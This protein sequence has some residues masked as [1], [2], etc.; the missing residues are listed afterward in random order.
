MVNQFLVTTA[1]EDTWPNSQDTPIIFLGEWCRLYSAKERWSR[2][3]ADVLPYHWDNRKKLYKDYQYLQGFYEQMLNNLSKE[4]NEIHSV[5]HST[6]YWRILV[7]PWL[8]FFIQMLFDRWSSIEQ[9]LSSYEV[10]E[11]II[12]DFPLESLVPQGMSDFHNYYISDEWNHYIYGQILKRKKNILLRNINGKPIKLFNNEKKLKNTRKKLSKKIIGE[13]LSIINRNDD[14]FFML[15]Y[16]PKIMQCKLELKLK[17]IPKF[18]FSIP[19]LRKSLNFNQRA[20]EIGMQCN[21]EFESIAKQLIPKMIPALYLEGYHSLVG[22]SKNVPWPK[23]PKVIWTSN[24]V[25]SDDV[26]K[27]WTAEKIEA[28]SKLLIGQHG[29]H[30]GIGK[31]YFIEEH[32]VAI[33][34]KF[35]SWGWS[36]RK[37]SSIIPIGQLKNKKPHGINHSNQKGLLLVCLTMPQY[38]YHMYST[39]M[40]SQY[41]NYLDDQ[42]TFVKTLPNLIQK[43]LTVRLYKTDYGWGQKAR[44]NEKHP[45]IKLESGEKNIKKLIAQSRIYVSTYN[46]TTYLESFSMNI[47][48]V[49]FWNPDHWEV[50][51][52]A[53]PYFNNL[54]KVGI[55]HE[56]PESAAKHIISVWDDVNCWWNDS[57]T[58]KSVSDFC[59]MYANTNADLLNKLYN[60]IQITSK[61]KP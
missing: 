15:T 17:Q 32:E 60:E 11:S 36:D 19:P 34:D 9:A 35:F 48:T 16:L 54:K 50:R 6:R 8:G 27:V 52:S 45:D 44:W 12:I 53:Q 49:I 39:I 57:L 51:D 22:L 56:T 10:A 4:L 29:G 55:F 30:Y 42:F 21:S 3:N 20:W 61:G 43:E 47:P 40:S 25:H 33:S 23:N 58:K 7:G 26:F 2:M 37:R 24:S 13:F 46:A 59:K 18:W 38:S 1:I 5:D 14:H 31:W 28:G 41:L